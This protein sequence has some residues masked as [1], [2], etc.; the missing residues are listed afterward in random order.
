[1]LYTEGNLLDE[2][3]DPIPVNSALGVTNADGD[4]V[5]D[6]YLAAGTSIDIDISNGVKVWQVST[7]ACIASDC[8]ILQDPEELPVFPRKA[9]WLFAALIVGLGLIRITKL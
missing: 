8:P 1:M 5:F 2:N 3:L 4:L 9:L 7:D 6:Y